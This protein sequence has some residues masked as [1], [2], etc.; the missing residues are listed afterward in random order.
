MKKIKPA[1]PTPKTARA[2]DVK[3][4]GRVVFDKFEDGVRFV[5]VRGP[6]SWCAYAGIQKD[7]PLAGFGY[8]DLMGVNAHGGL[9]YAGNGVTGVPDGYYW[10]GWDYAHAGDVSVY[11]HKYGKTPDEHDWTLDEVIEDSWSALYDIKKIATLAEKI[12]AK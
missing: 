3:E 2:I 5:I 11:D 7:H 10:Y 1:K 6:A 4:V 12:K 9:T 8:D